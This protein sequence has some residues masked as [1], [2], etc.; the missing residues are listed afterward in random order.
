MRTVYKILLVIATSA[1]LY[2][3]MHSTYLFNVCEFIV[4]SPDNWC[5]VFW[6]MDTGIHITTNNWNAGD[7]IGAWTGTGELYQPTIYDNIRDNT[8]FIFWHMVLPTFVIL[9][10]YQKDRLKK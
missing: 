9:L 8:G 2:L 3:I 5:M 4:N 1:M 6:N 7:G 10:I